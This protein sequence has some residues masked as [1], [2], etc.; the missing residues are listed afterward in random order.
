MNAFPKLFGVLINLREFSVNDAQTI[1]QLMN[2]NI[3][4]YLYEVPDPYSI[5][6]A[7]NFI[8]SA[9]SDFKSLR[10]LHF[11]IEYKGKSESTSNNLVLVRAICPNNIDLVNKKA[12][13]GYW[14]GEQYWVEA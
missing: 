14:I 6:D 5:E 3:S 10:A 1:A 8:K 12:N 7:L 11:A 2:Y 9:D 13:L 4:K